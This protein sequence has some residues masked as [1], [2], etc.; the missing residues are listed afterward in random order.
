MKKI[1]EFIVRALVDE[2]DCVNISEVNGAN[3]VI[4]ILKVAQKDL[5]KV[6]GKQGRTVSALRTLISAMSA[7]TRKNV[8]IDI[9]E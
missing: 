4:L 1:L 7:K 5:G 6:I 2:P 3:T 9:V 8:V